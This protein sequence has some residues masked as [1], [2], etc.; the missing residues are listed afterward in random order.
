[1]AHSSTTHARRTA[2][3]GYRHETQVSSGGVI[4]RMDG[5]RPSVCLI[6]RRSEGRR[7]LIWG[8]PKGHVE[9]GEHP[10]QTALREVREETGLVG[11]S[12][13]KLGAITYW[14]SVKEEQ[15][16]FF[17]TVHFYL[18]RYLSGRPEDHDDEVEQAA[19]FPINQALRRVTYANERAILLK[20]KRL[21]RR[22]VARHD[23]PS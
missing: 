18:L 9:A 1:M 13:R 7:R 10:Q 17:K 4:V 3:E 21:I 19:W 12:I 23:S 14:F 16:R 11:A 22:T 15:V 8:L 5:E 2:S 6:A 20:A